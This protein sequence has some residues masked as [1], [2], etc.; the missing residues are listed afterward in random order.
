MGLAVQACPGWVTDAIKFCFSPE[1]FPFGSSGLR[2][3]DP[4]RSV[5]Y[6]S[7]SQAI[8]VAKELNTRSWP[9]PPPWGVSLKT[10]GIG[11]PIF[12]SEGVR[13]AVF[14]LKELRCIQYLK[15]IYL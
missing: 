15:V 11:D 13:V 1:A 2:G 8:V 12:D 7:R 9:T 6:P 3:A 14:D 5:G 4:S 10:K